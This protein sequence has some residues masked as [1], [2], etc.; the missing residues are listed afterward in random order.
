[1]STNK[2]KDMKNEINNITA[3]DRITFKTADLSQSTLT[4]KVISITLDYNDNMRF[5]VSGYNSGKGSNGIMV[6]Q[7]QI[8]NVTKAK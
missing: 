1:V 4:R 2:Q 5:N 6:E 8:M 7:W 3:G